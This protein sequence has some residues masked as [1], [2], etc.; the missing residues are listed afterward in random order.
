M[1]AD[2][3]RL[4]TDSRIKAGHLSKAASFESVALP[5]LN[6]L[7]RTACR[8]LDDSAKAEDAVQ[9]TYLQAWKSFDRFEPGTNCR[10]WLFKIL[11]N[12]IHHYRRKRSNVFFLDLKAGELEEHI[13][14]TPPVPEEV[15]DEDVLLALGNLPHDYRAAILL[16]DVQEFSYKETA[17]ILKVPIGTVMS[18]LSRGR[19]I[20]RGLLS[21][22]AESHGIG[23]PRQ[24]TSR[25]P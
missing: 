4:D 16:A 24:M 2:A 13:A 15:S 20:L 21:R 1:V 6:D 22:V 5:H 11:L 9:E 12:N 23:P 19:N 8:L 3:I 10:A 14:Y 7:F 18:R 25:V 17:E